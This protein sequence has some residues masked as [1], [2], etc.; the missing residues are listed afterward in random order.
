MWVLAAVG[1]Q[2]CSG[3][4]GDEHA[5]RFVQW[6][7]SRLVKVQS[8]GLAAFG[9]INPHTADL[10]ATTTA[11]G[12]PASV[13]QHADLC[14]HRWPRLGLAIDF[15]DPGGEDSCGSEALIEAIRVGGPAAEAAGWH[16]AEGIRP[17]MSL[18]AARRI[19]P[20]AD[21]GPAATL[22]LVE[23]LRQGASGP[24]APVLVATIADG[25]IADLIFPIDAASG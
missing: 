20:E 13:Q 4:D 16:T 24:I 2:A 22:V 10:G 9:P 18:A 6:E 19:Y 7:D 25:R 11:F 17:G 8:V 21:R 3:N 5:V 14:R 15:A 1:L 23:R 12:E